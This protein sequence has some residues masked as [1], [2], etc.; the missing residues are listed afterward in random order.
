MVVTIGVV[1]NP[2]RSII[3]HS[4]IQ[5]GATANPSNSGGPMF[6]ARGQVIGIVVL[7]ANLQNTAFA[8]PWKRVREFLGSTSNNSP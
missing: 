7:K 2:D 5:T 4:F 8:I 3:R 1:S 6:N